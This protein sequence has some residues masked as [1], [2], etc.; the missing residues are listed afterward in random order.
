MTAY[1]FNKRFVAPIRAGLGLIGIMDGKREIPCELV[2]EAGSTVA[3]LFDP[4]LDMDPPTRPKRQTIRA[5]GKR[6]HARPGETIQLYT[7]MRTK[8]CRKIGDARC[9][10]VDPIR[11]QV[12]LDDAWLWVQVGDEPAGPATDAFAQADGF[13]CVEDMWLFWRE[14]HPDVRLFKG[15]LIK[16]EPL[17]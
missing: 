14:K 5:V 10:S 16:W 2:V 12:P 13:G 4:L 17:P 3:R 9:V 8:Q 11:I 1:N 15:V 7:A 6:R